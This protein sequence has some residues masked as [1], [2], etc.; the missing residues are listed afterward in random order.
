VSTTTQEI[1][2]VG[3]A[4]INVDPEVH[5]RLMH[6]QYRRKCGGQRVSFSQLIL[7]AANKAGFAKGPV[8]IGGGNA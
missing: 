1:T 3:R 7:E 6:E 5:E 2:K 8:R 4:S